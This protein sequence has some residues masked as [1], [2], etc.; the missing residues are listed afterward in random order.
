MMIIF[1]QGKEPVEYIFTASTKTKDP[2]LRNHLCEYMIKV[3]GFKA[4]HI[5]AW[6]I[7]KCMAQHEERNG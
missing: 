2:L 4:E 5:A 1:L 3:S 6:N 7:S